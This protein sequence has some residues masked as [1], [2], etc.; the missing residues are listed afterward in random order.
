MTRPGHPTAR[1][2]GFT[3]MELLVTMTLVA[4]ILAIIAPNLGSFLPEARLEGSGKQILRR[5]DWARSEARIQGKQVS[6]DFDLDRG[7][8]RIVLPPEQQLTR[9][10]EAWTL[11]EFTEDWQRLENDVVFA[12]AGDAKT[13]MVQRGVYRITFDEF[14]FSGDQVLALRLV[15]DPTMV[16]SLTLQ[17]LNGSVST[18][19]SEKGEI[20]TLQAPT[21]AA[22]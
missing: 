18:Q 3:L 17:G 10:Q 13:G 11:E 8:W 15:S 5:L 4:L 19:L 6:L 12:G 9:D 20:P 2:G 16:W 14:G 7:S 21:E 22:F 1:S